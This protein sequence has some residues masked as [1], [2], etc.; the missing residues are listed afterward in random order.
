MCTHLYTETYARA[1]AR[2][3]LCVWLCVCVRSRLAEP[4]NFQ[5]E[6]TGRHIVFAFLPLAKDSIEVVDRRKREVCEREKTQNH[7]CHCLATEPTR[8]SS[9]ALAIQLLLLQFCTLAM[10][11][12]S[13]GSLLDRFF[14]YCSCRLPSR[15]RVILHVCDC[16]IENINRPALCD[17]NFTV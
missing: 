6:G 12:N 7:S 13:L 4:C 1:H 11:K 2:A 15:H 14:F 9:T 17:R 16:S 10:K 3:W 8:P 5:S